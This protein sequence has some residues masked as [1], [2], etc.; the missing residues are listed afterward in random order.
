MI[1]VMEPRSTREDI[2]RVVR[3][4]GEMGVRSHVIEGAT[5]SVVE[6]LEADNGFDPSRVERAPR[7][8]KVLT[9]P[10]PIV[11]A[12]RHEKDVTFEVP[13]GTRA[14]MG[15]KK[16]GV[17]AGPC[18]VESESGVLEI[19][20]AV[21][22]AGAVALRGGAF[23]PR[24]SPYTFQGHEERGLEML[25]R[26]REVTGLAVVTEVMCC[27][28]VDI[29][30]PYADV[31]Q[32]GSR[33]MHNTPLL[34]TVGEQEKPVLLKRGWSATLEEFLLAA[35][36]IMQAG[37]RNIILCERGIRTHE[38]YVRNTLALSVVPAIKR[39]SNLPI[40]V[41][42]SHGTGRAYLVPPMCYAGIA[43]GADGLLVEVHARPEKAWSDG[44]QTLNPEQFRGMMQGL[45]ALAEAAGREL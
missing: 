35:E 36:Y 13:L 31:L 22:E 32:V 38:E 17:I 5:R 16:I 37:N 45:K 20:A 41:D 29:V 10:T 6:V 25:A 28:H 27:K 11:A 24:S 39:I 26:A 19:A 4:L 7:V 34:K 43:C 40:I 33:N 21:A 23:K 18:S 8:E 9:R 14:V 1:V 30:A 15:G 3:I 44:D 12:G 2:D 42:P